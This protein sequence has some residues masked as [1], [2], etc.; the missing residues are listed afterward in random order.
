MAIAELMRA[1]HVG[2]RNLKNRLSA[3]LGTGK[4]LVATDRGTPKYYLIPY[5]ELVELVE[6]LEEAGDPALVA[7][8]RDA[9][10]AYRRGGW[11]PASRLL[12]KLDAKRAGRRR[13]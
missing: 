11:I 8:V 4:P 10:Q 9:R 3:Y 12:D 1:E 5:A 6:M 7:R 2:I 13:R